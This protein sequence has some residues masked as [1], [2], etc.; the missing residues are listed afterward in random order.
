MCSNNIQ[1][2]LNLRLTQEVD[3]YIIHSIC[4]LNPEEIKGEPIVS[5]Q[6]AAT[7]KLTHAQS[8]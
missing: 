4:A 2:L 3:D 5:F 8:N 7:P 1:P 6:K